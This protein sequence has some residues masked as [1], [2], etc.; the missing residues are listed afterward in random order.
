MGRPPLRRR[1]SPAPTAATP[2]QQRRRTTV[3]CE[4]AP[5]RCRRLRCAELCKALRGAARLW[6]GGASAASLLPHAGVPPWARERRSTG[7]TPEAHD[8]G[9]EEQAEGEAPRRSSLVLDLGGPPGPCWPPSLQPLPALRPPLP[10][11]PMRNL[12]CATLPLCAPHRPHPRAVWRHQPLRHQ[13]RRHVRPLQRQPPAER[14]AGGAARH[15]AQQRRHRRPHRG[16]W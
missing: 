3:R 4:L 9:E 8:E 14:A 10:P 13:P 7:A 1:A 2:T 11:P 5:A 15:A 6:Y 16:L 12:T